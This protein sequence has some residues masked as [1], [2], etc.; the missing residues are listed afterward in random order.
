VS[1]RGYSKDLTD[2]LK[3]ALRFNE[4]ERIDFLKLD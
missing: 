2:I 1:D 3:E 4:E